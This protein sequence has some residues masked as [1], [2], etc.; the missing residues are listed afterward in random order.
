MQKNILII[1][2]IITLIGAYLSGAIESLLSGDSGEHIRLLGGAIG[3]AIGTL[4]MRKGILS[5][6]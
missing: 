6:D 2:I 3:L 4:L 5:N 1:G